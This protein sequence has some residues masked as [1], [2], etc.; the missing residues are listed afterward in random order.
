MKHLQPP[1]WSWRDASGDFVHQWVKPLGEQFC[2]IWC[3][4]ARLFHG[5]RLV[6]QELLYIQWNSANCGKGSPLIT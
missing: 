4:M 2:W 5:H 6:C 3:F 1:E